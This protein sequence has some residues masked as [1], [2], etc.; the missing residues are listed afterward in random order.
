MM[1][2]PSHNHTQAQ[3]DP[4]GAFHARWKEWYLQP[5]L[6]LLLGNSDTGFLATMPALVYM[7]V[8]GA[9][10]HGRF[11]E[12]KWDDKA[13]KSASTPKPVSIILPSASS[14]YSHIDDK[15]LI[16]GIE[17]VLKESLEK[18]KGLEDHNTKE[19]FEQGV[20]NCI[21]HMGFLYCGCY[22]SRDSAHPEAIN[23]SSEGNYLV[24]NPESLLRDCLNH[25]TR[26]TDPNSNY[27][28]GDVKFIEEYK[29]AIRSYLSLIP[30]TPAAGKHQNINT[31]SVG[32]LEDV[33]SPENIST[34]SGVMP[35][36]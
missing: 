5:A 24:V 29:S 35:T 33:S 10:R 34:V 15:N 28:N 13:R 14:E 3:S 6:D 25:L 27:Y 23:V 32:S 1:V 2:S 8:V 26:F 4:F 22:L 36:K 12:I 18:C 21:F 20:R 30:Q 9:C 7:E 17:D 19:W 31:L 11:P 16:A